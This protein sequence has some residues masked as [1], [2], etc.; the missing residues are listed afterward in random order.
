MTATAT[1]SPL[2]AGTVRHGSSIGQ[3]LTRRDGPL[4]VTGQAR[5]SADNLPPGT[6]HAALCVARIAQG[7]RHRPRRGR[8]RGPSRRRRGDDGRGNAPAL[9]KDPD[10]KDGPFIFRLDLLQNDRVRYAN[11]PIAVVIAETLE[12][13][14]EGARLLAPTYAAETPRIGLDSGE[15]RSRRIRSASARPPVQSEGDV[16]AGLAAASRDDRGHL[17]DAGPVPQRHG[18]ARGGGQL[19]RRPADAATCRPRRWRCRRGGSPACSASA[20]TTSTSRAPI[21]AAASARRACPPARR[22]SPA[23]RPSSWAGR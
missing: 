20:P 15:R 7:P 17:R 6:L 23:W 3:P 9:A 2:A 1:P 11:Q 22:C 12:A 8:R 13:A 14:T 18:A 19:G 5:F 21:S 4:K 10:A 16:E